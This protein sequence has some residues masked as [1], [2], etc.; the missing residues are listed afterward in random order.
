VLDA[1]YTVHDSAAVVERIEHDL[2]HVLDVVQRADPHLHSLVLTGGFARGEGAT[3]HGVPQNDYDLIAIRGTGRPREPYADTR[4]QLEADLGLHVDLATVPRWRL[5]WVA[6]SIF[7]YETALRGRVLWGRDLLDK[8]PIRDPRKID[9][10]EG[11]RL[12]VNRAAGLLLVTEPAQAHARRLQA[13]KAIL[14]AADARLLTMGEF[15][16]S[17]TERWLRVRTLRKAGRILAVDPDWLNWAFAYK[18][19][20]ASAPPREAGEAW[21]VAAQSLLDAVPAALRHAG[22]RSLDEYARRDGL[23][24]FL[25]YLR[26]SRSVAGARRM[27]L[28]PTGRVRVATLRLL[29]ASLDGRVRPE[30]AQRSFGNLAPGGENPLAC[31]QAL[32]RA[33]LQ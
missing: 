20:P 29:A 3:L 16:P 33:T 1:H 14:A 12:L 5:A 11:L 22:L 6:P 9:P 27:I 19:D 31:L 13:A 10:A 26:R 4:A 32:R 8:I 24:S 25:F 28:H 21:R 7:W 2:S 17:Q 18:V 15:A 23:L 30:E